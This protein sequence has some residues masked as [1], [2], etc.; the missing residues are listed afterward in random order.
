MLRTRLMLGLLGLMAAALCVAGTASAFALRFYLIGQTD[1]QVRGAQNLISSHGLALVASAAPLLGGTE[2]RHTVAPTA[3]VVELRRPDGAVLAVAGDTD[4]PIPNGELLAHVDH[5]DSRV[6]A[7]APFSLKVG[8]VSYRAVVGILPGG[9]TDL[10]ALPIRPV[11]DTTIRLV[12]VEVAAGAAVLALAGAAAWFLLGRGLRPLREIAGTAAA[13]AGG[14]LARRVPLGRPNTE[15][16]QLAAALN[17]MLGQIQA[18]FEERRRSSDRLRRFVA[19]ASHELRT[20]VTSIRGY[21]DLLRQGIVPPAGRDDALRRVQDE[22]RRMG[23]LVDDMLYLAHLDE[24][25]PLDRHVVDLAALARDSV[26]DAAAVEPDRPLTVHAPE[27]CP[28]VADAD[29]LRQVLANLLSNVRAH[30]PPDTTAEVSVTRQA[31]GSVCLE[32]RDR[33]P[34][35]SPSDAGRAFDRFHRSAGSRGGGRTGSGLGMAIVAAIAAA[36]GGTATL[37]STPGV[38]TTVRVVLPPDAMQEPATKG[39]PTTAAG[40]GAPRGQ[41]PRSPADPRVGQRHARPGPDDPPSTLGRD[42]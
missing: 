27:Q 19:D 37:D 29:A 39:L 17:S 3:F 31:A 16:G 30:T 26:A 11:T 24:A 5:L 13:I 22:T 38:G 35:M 8:H 7:G 18:A 20:P 25:R 1:S 14:D 9:V 42:G 41:Q 2:L 4:T 40:I 15:T 21:I 32:V 23:T 34:G 28:V 33:G 12:L 10:I 6:K 36:H